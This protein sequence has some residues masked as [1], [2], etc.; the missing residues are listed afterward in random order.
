MARRRRPL[1]A[2]EVFR[3][4][5]GRRTQWLVDRL[6]EKGIHVGLSCMS[7]YKTGYRTPEDHV[8]EAIWQTLSPKAV[9][10]RIR[11]GTPP[12]A[13]S[14]PRSVPPKERND[15]QPHTRAQTTQAEG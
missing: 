4:L 11:E 1:V 7:N 13:G 12:R 2:A 5:D 14:R 8:L 15:A 3:R 10:A 9:A 6:E